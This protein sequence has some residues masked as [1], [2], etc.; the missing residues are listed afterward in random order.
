MRNDDKEKT[1]SLHLHR[2]RNVHQPA[3]CQLLSKRL[4][5]NTSGIPSLTWV[6]CVEMCRYPQ[7]HTRRRDRMQT[8]ACIST[9][10]VCAKVEF[11]TLSEIPIAKNY[12]FINVLKISLGLKEKKILFYISRYV[13]HLKECWRSWFQLSWVYLAL[14]VYPIITR[15]K[16]SFMSKLVKCTC[17]EAVIN[18][19]K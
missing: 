1:I 16:I 10:I 19:L 8:S 6:G 4:S 14:H 2:Q 15:D 3:L 11:A 9:R 12:D 13:T 18:P 5:D 7:F 17:F